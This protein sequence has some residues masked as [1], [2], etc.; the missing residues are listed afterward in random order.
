MKSFSLTMFQ[1]GTDAMFT[2]TG[3]QVMIQLMDM[4]NEIGITA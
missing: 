3:R 4:I 2:R 1:R